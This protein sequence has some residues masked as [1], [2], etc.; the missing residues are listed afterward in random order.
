MPERASEPLKLTVTS[1][2]FQPLALGAGKTL[3]LAVG[4]VL[5]ILIVSQPGAS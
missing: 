2:L 3:T 4:A 1:V 5:S